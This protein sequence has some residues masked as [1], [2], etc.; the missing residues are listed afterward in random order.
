MSAVVPTWKQVRM[1]TQVCKVLNLDTRPGYSEALA[2]TVEAVHMDRAGT[3]I[4]R[5]VE[6]AAAKNRPAPVIPVTMVAA[7]ARWFA[8][9]DALTSLGVG[10]GDGTG[11][12]PALKYWGHIEN[13][14]DVRPEA[15]A[16]EFAARAGLPEAPMVLVAPQAPV[17]QTPAPGVDDKL[18]RTALALKA[19][20]FTPAQIGIALKAM[21]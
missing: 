12:V 1:F 3:E 4:N 15:K 17:V 13:R 20:G 9:E 14:R 5:W 21:S 2:A 11:I 6:E 18:V 16:A 7:V 10:A 19:A 8:V